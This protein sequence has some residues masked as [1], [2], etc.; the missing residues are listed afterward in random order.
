MEL[1]LNISGSIERGAIE[2][3]RMVDVLEDNNKIQIG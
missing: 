1:V 3:I 2:D